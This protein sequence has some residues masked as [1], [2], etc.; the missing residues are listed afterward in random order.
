MRPGAAA[1]RKASPRVAENV[2]PSRLFP[3]ASRLGLGC[4]SLGSRIGHRAAEEALEAAFAWGLN[5]FD[6]SPSYGDG[7]AEAIVGTFA[8]SRRDRVH[9]CTKVGMAPAAV[10]PLM[11][12]LKPLAQRAVRLAPALRSLM[13]HARQSPQRVPIRG[14]VI[15]SSL[16]KSLRRL[17]TDHVD[18]L[19]LHYPEPDDLVR[20]DVLRALE[21]AT[22]TGKA[23]VVGVA[24]APETAQS[25]VAGCLPIGH[26]QFKA[27]YLGDETID[28]AA[29]ATS[30]PSVAVHS[31]FAD[32]ASLQ[33]RLEG[34][35][36]LTRSVLKRHAYGMDIGQALRG[37]ML[38]KALARAPNA[39][40]VVSL[41][42][43]PHLQFACE[44]LKHHDG[45]KAA[46]LL[47]D[48]EHLCSPASNRH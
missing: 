28:L 16:E 47:N 26:I 36:Y 6:L 34:S 42:Q 24:G 10:H 13:S 8:R 41:L 18:V 39:V 20:D 38:D 7:E 5:W 3:T 31:L 22:T 48:L 19:A 35:T 15:L 27:S 14:E 11:R 37:A 44:R 23:K 21:S 4:A 40:I 29:I 33:S 45:A 12:A 43:R 32:V 2:A 17:R 9:I 46:A 25:V 30:A 1:D